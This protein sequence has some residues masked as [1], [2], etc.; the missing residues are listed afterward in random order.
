[1]P[2]TSALAGALDRS[3][4]LHVRLVIGAR[5]TKCPRPSLDCW[6]LSTPI[7]TLVRHSN[8]SSLVIRTKLL[9][10]FLPAASLS[11]RNAICPLRRYLTL[12]RSAHDA[13][14]RFP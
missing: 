14:S 13:F 10:R 1:M 6:Q 4:L 3:R 8:N 7:G 2:T 12:W 11:L 5:P 9:A